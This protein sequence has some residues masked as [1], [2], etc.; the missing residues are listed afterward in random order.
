MYG[1][2]RKMENQSER[3]KEKD[4]KRERGQLANVGG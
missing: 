4:H 2:M 3:E 1:E